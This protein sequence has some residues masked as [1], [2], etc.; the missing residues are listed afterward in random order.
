MYMKSQKKKYINLQT[1]QHHDQQI[2][3]H[4][5]QYDWMELVLINTL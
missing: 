3:I 5:L 1:D 2:S 4:I